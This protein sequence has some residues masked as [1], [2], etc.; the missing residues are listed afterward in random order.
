MSH[1]IERREPSGEGDAVH[2][3]PAAAQSGDGDGF[4]LE[5]IP[6]TMAKAQLGAAMK[7]AIRR[8]DSVLKEFGTPAV[9]DRMCS[10]DVSDVLGRI[11]ARADTREEFLLALMK[12]SGLYE[13]RQIAERK[14]A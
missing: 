5:Q 1:S 12:A 11:W 6:L 10:G 8:T 4:T 13:V 14:R 2:P 3:L 7:R 9:V